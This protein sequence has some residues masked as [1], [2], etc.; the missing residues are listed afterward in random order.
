M[1]T[2][3]KAKNRTRLELK[4]RIVA[5]KIKTPTLLGICS[6]EVEGSDARF[7]P[8]GRCT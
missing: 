3:G 8:N 1:G 7:S 2:T 5:G 4:T 6:G